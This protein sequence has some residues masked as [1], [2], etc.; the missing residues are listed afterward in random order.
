MF[1]TYS[2]PR[3]MLVDL[4][5]PG[6]Y[7]IGSG[8]LVT[9]QVVYE[10]SYNISTRIATESQAIHSGTAFHYTLTSPSDFSPQTVLTTT[11]NT[12]GRAVAQARSMTSET[13]TF[14]YPGVQRTSDIL[15]EDQSW[16]GA[17]ETE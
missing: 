12:G 2:A 14:D 13:L 5:S 6:P 10:C 7:S 3:E 17:I 1:R 4:A 9:A 11:F 15:A 8:S 16:M